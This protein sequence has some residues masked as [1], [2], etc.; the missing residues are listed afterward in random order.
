MSVYLQ[1]ER[2][3]R[4]GPGPAEPRAMSWRLNTEEALQPDPGLPWVPPAGQGS[5]TTLTAED[6]HLPNSGC[7]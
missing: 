2:Q 6:S 1:A 5:C 3:G 4:R 7:H